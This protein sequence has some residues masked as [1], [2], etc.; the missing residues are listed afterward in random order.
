MTPVT[1]RPRKL[2]NCLFHF[3][4]LLP[5]QPWRLCVPDGIITGWRELPDLH[6]TLVLCCFKLLKCCSSPTVMASSD[7]SNI[8]LPEKNFS[9]LP[10]FFPLWDLTTCYKCLAPLKNGMID[11]GNG[12]R[13]GKGVNLPQ[14][15]K[16]VVF[17]GFHSFV[18][19]FKQTY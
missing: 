10:L 7:S 5:Q 11:R 16:K 19:C 17:L 3:S 12:K 15:F 9:L 8:L 14:F 1:S 13:R 6:Q 4:L 2:G 18:L